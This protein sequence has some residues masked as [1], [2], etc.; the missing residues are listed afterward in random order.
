MLL[1]T[2]RVLRTADGLAKHHHFS[3]AHK[4]NVSII[5]QLFLILTLHSLAAS[6]DDKF[7]TIIRVAAGKI[8]E[9][10]LAE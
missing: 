4:C 3:D 5:I 6:S 2:M 7:R 10:M 1:H 8:S 9:V